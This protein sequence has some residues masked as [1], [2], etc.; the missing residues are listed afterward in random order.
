MAIFLTNEEVRSLLPMRECVDI[1][2]RVFRDEADG[3]AVNLPRQHMPLP[4]GM[5]RTVSGVAHGFGV[6][7]MKTYGSVR[8]EGWRRTRY[9]VLLYSLEDGL[10][11]AI[12]EARDLGQIRTG[13]VAGMAT[14]H[15]APAGAH[16]VGIVGTGWE[17]RAQMEA[18][19]VVR[20][21]THVKAYSRSAEHRE[22][23]AAEMRERL[24]LDVDPVA[25]P[26]ECVRDADIVITVTSANEPVLE[27]S[28]I[29]PG[30]HINAVGATTKQ[31]RELDLEAVRRAGLVV[32]EQMEQAKADCGELIYA[33]ESGGFDWDAAVLLKDIVSGVVQR[34]AGEAITLFDSLGVATE[35]LAAA[36]FVAQQAREQGI[37]QELP[38]A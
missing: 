20:D 27:G 21:I 10:L 3:K 34:P 22:T 33:A 12:M 17:A 23:F 14:K 36:A 11:E 38:F 1:M 26:E 19:S 32:V 5:H 15:L 37:G 31:R 18:M 25:T 7:G 24:G 29:A 28:W 9:L 35:D 2:E 16:T 4:V 6:Y 13:A 8:K 30:S